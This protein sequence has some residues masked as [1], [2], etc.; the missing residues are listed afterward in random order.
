VKATVDYYLVVLTGYRSGIFSHEDF[1]DDHD[2]LSKDL[3]LFLFEVDIIGLGER[4]LVAQ[5]LQ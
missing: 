4:D 5:F 1:N 3:H 2:D